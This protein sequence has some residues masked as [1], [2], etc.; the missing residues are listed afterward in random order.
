MRVN[1]SFCPLG[2][3]KSKSQSPVLFSTTPLKGISVLKE[4]HGELLICMTP[5]IVDEMGTF[6][7]MLPSS[8]K[9][10]PGLPLEMALIVV[11][12]LGGADMTGVGVG[13]GIMPLLPL[14]PA[15]PMLSN[16]SKNGR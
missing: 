13:A 9:L 1:D 16:T 10:R 2:N 14:H 7:F 3:V 15:S 5:E 8:R 12:P 6:P 11:K 4:K